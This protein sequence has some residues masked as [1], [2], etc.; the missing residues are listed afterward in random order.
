M[1]DHRETE[2]QQSWDVTFEDVRHRQILDI[3]LLTTPAERFAKLEELLEMLKDVLP[4][5][6]SI[7]TW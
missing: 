2:R 4:R 5:Q 7:S 3:A 1:Q 6:E